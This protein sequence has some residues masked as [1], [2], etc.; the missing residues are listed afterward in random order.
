MIPV[1]LL[2]KVRFLSDRPCSQLVHSSE[3]MRV[4]VFGLEPGQVIPPHVSPSSVLM[5]VIQGSGTFTVAEGV[6]PV[7]AG[8]VTICAPNE[9]HGMAAGEERMVI[10][11]VIAPSPV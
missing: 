9:P 6:R 4:V 7:R 8:D 11:A 10:L 3:N 1:S 5:A 2:E